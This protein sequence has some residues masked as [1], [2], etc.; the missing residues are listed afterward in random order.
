MKNEK[1]PQQLLE[2]IQELQ[3]R[4]QEAEDT[5]QA[6]REGAVDAVVVSG[7]KGDQIFTLSGE[8]QI[9]RRLVETMGEAGLTTT[10]EGK[11]HFCN[12]QFSEML[13]LPME[14]IVGHEL[15]EFIKE[16]DRKKM[17]A[18]ITKAQLEPSRRRLVFRAA[19]GSFVPAWVSANLLEYGGAMRVCLVAMDQT[20]LE[21]SKE[22]TRQISEQ[23]EELMAQ[24]EELRSQNEQLIESESQL[25]KLNRMLKALSNSDQIMMRA[26]DE[27]SYLQEVCRII[28]RDCGYAMVWIGFAHDDIAKIIRPVACAGFE[29]EYLE[30]LNFTWADTKRGRSPTGTA[31][32][33]GKVSIC[34]NK[35]KDTPFESCPQEDHLDYASAIALPFFSEG[36]ILGAITIY[37]KEPV[38]FSKEDIDLL[39]ELAN[40][41]SFGITTIR[42]QAARMQ[43]EKDLRESH[44]RLELS[45][46][47]G[48]I[49][50]WDFDPVNME[51]RWDKRCS[52]MFGIPAETGI[53]YEQFMNLVYTDDH[54]SIEQAFSQSSDE[55]KDYDVEYRAKLSDG[56]EHWFY[57]KGRC[58]F[59]DSGKCVRMA[60]VV[61]D[62]T[63]RKK[64]IEALRESEEK[65]R[66]LFE[67]IDEGFCIIQVLFDNNEKPI[68]YIFLSVNPALE[69]HSGIVNA[70]GKKMK[71]IA[72]MHEEYW[73]DIYGKVALTGESIR[74]EK[75][76]GQLH[77]IFDVYACRIGIPEERKV[78]V[79]FNDITERK[80]WED[81]LKQLNDDLNRSNTELEDFANIVSHDLREP[82]R[83]ITGFMELLQKK[84]KDKLDDKANEYIEFATSGGKTMSNMLTGLLEYSRVQTERLKF[85]EVDINDILKDSIN[86]LTLKINE[87]ST[88]ITYDKLPKVHGLGPQLTQLFQNLIQNAIKFKSEQNPKIHIGAE[89]DERG[90]LFFVRDNGIGIDPK[91]YKNIFTIFHRVKSERNYEGS[92]VGLAVCKRIV[93]RHKGQ[94]WVESELGKGSTFYFTIP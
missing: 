64:A 21:A 23:R 41:V 2:Q 67:S 17:I 3:I 31:I 29:K 45:N 71:D 56:S 88:K 85:S 10:L 37:S 89:R 91:Y 35:I 62:I 68:D 55:N 53:T 52:K 69:R 84:Y 8:E 93:E 47:A 77:R 5:L 92:G 1:T 19:N 15:D 9:Y 13:G 73:F 80:R 70:I 72:P 24:K 39:T 59:D 16:S 54:K 50:T 61:I 30:S 79:I 60:G 75:Q 76:A 87:T 51:I 6:I 38:N 63:Q 27:I 32:R 44:S 81:E 58:F 43:A 4:L 74:F 83:A 14:D 34:G 26:T 18:L 90:W 48:G 25:L 12:R 49:G 78:A 11:I 7:P 94:I 82:L 33:T 57:A 86:N 20:E 46:E 40:D 28:E 22:A 65:F 42:I 66:T 36:R